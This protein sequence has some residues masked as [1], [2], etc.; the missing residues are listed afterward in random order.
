[1]PSRFVLHP[2]QD[3]TLLIDEFIA[4]DD[5]VLDSVIP[6][7]FEQFNNVLF[8]EIGIQPEGLALDFN[9]I[10]KE[11][12]KVLSVDKASILKAIITKDLNVEFNNQIN[13]VITPKEATITLKIKNSNIDIKILENKVEYLSD[14]IELVKNVVY[15][16]NPFILDRPRNLMFLLNSNNTSLNHEDDLYKKLLQDQENTNLID[17]ML[18]QEKFNE[19]YSL[20]DEICDGDIIRR[21]NRRITL[22]LDKQGTPIDFANVSSGL[23][24]FA[25]LKQLL[26]N[27]I[28][29]PRGIIIL[30]EPEI[31]LHP[32]WQLVFAELI[33]LIQKFFNMH[34]LMTTHSPYF[35]EAIDAYSQKHK[36]E[37]RCSFYL[38][39]NDSL[40][41][42]VVRVEDTNEIYSQLAKPL[43]K[44]EEVFANA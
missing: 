19:I 31:H 1:M 7:K 36:I 22:S 27:G 11:I 29:E 30:D 44:L 12:Q 39:K 28:L 41:S 6:A 33:V 38:A 15:L 18:T 42:S 3:F 21:G 35:L 34:I 5:S 2:R 40:E 23:K 9:S 37:D 32:E 14:G 13:N 10:A 16:D 4:L 43:Q 17:E 25:I 24:T 26:T 20:V 8:E